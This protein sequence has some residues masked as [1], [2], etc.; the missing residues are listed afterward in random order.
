VSGF[1]AVQ[2][3]VLLIFCLPAFICTSRA[4]ESVPRPLVQEGLISLDVVVTD[5]SG[6]SVSGLQLNDF[7]LLDNG[8]P[9]GILSYQAFNG[10]SGSPVEVILLIDLLD[11]PSS[12]ASLERVAVESFLQRN[13]SHL[14]AP[15]S[16]FE[17]YENGL[18]MVGQSSLD[19]NALAEEIAHNREAQLIRGTVFRE[20]GEASIISGT[21]REF[22]GL[23]ALQALADIATAERQ[24]PGRKLLLWIGPG[25]GIGSGAYS[26]EKLVGK[27]N[28]FDMVSWFST[29]LRDARITI[30][31]FSVGEDAPS[32]YYLD[33]LS[34]L[35]SVQQSSF[36]YLNRKVL[37]IESGGRVLGPSGDLLNQIL[38]C[39][40]EAGP[41]YRISFDPAPA[42]HPDEYRH[43]SV[44][45]RRTGLTARSNTGYYDQ[46]YYSDSP[47][48]A[49]RVTVEQLD[50]IFAGLRS[51][52]DAEVANQLSKLGLTERLNDAKLSSWIAALH[53]RKAR[54]ALL[55]LAD[56]SVFLPPPPADVSNIPAPDLTEQKHIVSLA[57]DYLNETIPKLP[58]FLA[59]RTTVR[60]EETPEFI[61]KNARIDYRAL[62]V[63]DI[64]EV[65]VL[66]RNGNEFLDSGGAKRKKQKAGERHLITYGT[67]GPLLGA[68][69]DAIRD[70]GDL[71]WVRWERSPGG[72]R[73]V[74]RYVI[75]VGKSRYRVG[76]CCLP[77]GDG[78]SAFEAPVGFHGEL[79]IDPASGALLRFDVKADL[80]STTP[81]IRSDIMIEY[82]PVE[83]GG[84]QYICPVKSISIMRG[85]SVVALTALGDSFRTYGPYAT[86]LNE[87]AYSEYHKFRV[88]ARMLPGVET[89]N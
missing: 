11:L 30:L 42:D 67:F 65:T 87:I 73:A 75:P 28:V 22:P 21:F 44:Q 24:K 37:A 6:K 19:G 3:I 50:Q 62:H 58:D 8:E 25:W 82:G 39:V 29:L 81:L 83:I 48:T 20:R 66:Y 84:Q 51:E 60:Y 38:S 45:V 53:G 69:M 52:P 85:R 89:A 86:A 36:M 32:Q 18:W 78:T 59:R 72:T 2:R 7:N 9:A 80:K 47:R 23:S 26:G 27:Q 16:V 34:G 76:G 4:Q 54:Q 56:A 74:F 71:T 64:S 15:V 70:F 77:D 10:D 33:F 40:Q 17:M 88:K 13:G 68:A 55:A 41:F 14:S 49:N 46:P 57:L 63:A 12:L 1:S 43:I 5:P 35:K 61:E 31:N 79:A